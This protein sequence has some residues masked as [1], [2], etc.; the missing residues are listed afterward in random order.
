MN[1]AVVSTDHLLKAF[2]SDGRSVICDQDIK[3]EYLYSG[4]LYDRS[5]ASDK[6]TRKLLKG[7]RALAN[8]R[9]S[10][11]YRILSTHATQHVTNRL[12]CSKN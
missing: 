8:D 11:Y 7:I 1:Y 12:I 4:G 5:D 6:K 10:K 2:R 3:I 9:H